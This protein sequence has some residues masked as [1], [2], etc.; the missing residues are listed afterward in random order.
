MLNGAQGGN[1]SVLID[2]LEGRS[3]AN[4]SARTSLQRTFESYND[5]T[6]DFE[7]N[8]KEKKYATAA[9]VMT[10]R[11]VIRYMICHLPSDVLR[12]AT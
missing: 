3:A 10:A 9:V 1:E 7:K 12:H 2:V 5:S 4:D 6:A 8:D 11:L